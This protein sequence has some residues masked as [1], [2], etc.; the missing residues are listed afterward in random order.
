MAHAGVKAAGPNAGPPFGLTVGRDCVVTAV[1][2]GS[3]SQA[4]GVAAGDVLRRIGGTAVHSKAQAQALLADAAEQQQPGNVDLDVVRREE[5]RREREAVPEAE[6][7]PSSRAVRSPPAVVEA[8]VGLQQHGAPTPIAPT[9]ITIIAAII[10]VHPRCLHEHV[11]CHASFDVK[12]C[13]SSLVL[14][15]EKA[16]LAWLRSSRASTR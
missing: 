12:L 6:S 9:T 8:L 16:A 2:A 5:P 11:S 7:P 1:R 14:S 15:R 4:A 10:I 3:A 13:S